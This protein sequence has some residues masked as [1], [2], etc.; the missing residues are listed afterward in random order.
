MDDII[1]PP[2][3]LVAEFGPAQR[4]VNVAEPTPEVLSYN[5]EHLKNA[6]D[7]PSFEMMAF[8]PDTHRYYSLVPP[9]EKYFSV[10]QKFS[11]MI[12]NEISI[13]KR[14]GSVPEGVWI[15]SYENRLV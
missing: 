5:E 14:A 6:W 9:T 11:N 7:E 4:Y 15:R 1:V 13:L 12:A 10:G 2:Y 3:Q 8:A